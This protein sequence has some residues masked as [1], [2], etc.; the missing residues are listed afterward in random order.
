LLTLGVLGIVFELQAPGWG[1]SGTLGTIFLLLFFGG[2]YL[3]GLASVLDA[4]LFAVGIALLALE[5]FVIPGFGIAGIS[6]ILCIFAA[7]YLALVKRPIPQFSWD[8][9]QVNSALL[10][11]F[12]VIVGVAL[13]TI[14][15]WKVFPHTRLKSLLVLT[16]REEPA[17]GYVAGE[18][19][20]GLIGSSGISITH[21]RPAGKAYIGER[22]VEVQTQGEFIEK[23]RQVRVVKVM[24]NKVFVAEQKPDRKQT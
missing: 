22:P 14:I 9:Q 24:G 20:D 11:F 13:G 10:V 7:V 6:G 23:D 4:L 5:I 12:F 1:I 21:L 15:L 16:Q 8:F 3:A 19:L 17:L 18:N 2:H